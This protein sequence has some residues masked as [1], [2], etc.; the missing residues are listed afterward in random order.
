MIPSASSSVHFPGYNPASS[1]LS[2]VTTLTL[3]GCFMLKYIHEVDK[4]NIRMYFNFHVRSRYL[5]STFNLLSTCKS[6]THYRFWGGALFNAACNVSAN[7]P[8]QKTIIDSDIQKFLRSYEL[9]RSTNV[10]FKAQLADNA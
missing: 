1:L 10:C 5:G 6:M 9:C 8:G 2:M 4:Y 7:S 3:H